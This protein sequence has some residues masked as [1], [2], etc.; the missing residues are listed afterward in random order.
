M[1]YRIIR[2]FSLIPDNKKICTKCKIP[3]SLDI[4][5]IHHIDGKRYNNQGENLQLLC[6][7]CHKGLIEGNYQPGTLI[8]VSY[9]FPEELMKRID[10]KS[11]KEK[12]SNSV[13][14]RRILTEKLNS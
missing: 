13:L 1:D 3:L 11:K 6:K 2:F 12:V 4:C 14:V 5:E 9:R 7:N 10:E 8:N